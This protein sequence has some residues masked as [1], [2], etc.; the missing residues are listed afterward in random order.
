MFPN[1]HGLR[2]IAHPHHVEQMREDQVRLLYSTSH[3]QSPQPPSGQ[4]CRP[5]HKEKGE[6]THPPDSPEQGQSFWKLN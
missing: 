4:R 1:F 6:D 3:P 5:A 2:L